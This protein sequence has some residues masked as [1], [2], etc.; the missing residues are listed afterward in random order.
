MLVQTRSLG[1]IKDEHRLLLE[2]VSMGK[3]GNVNAAL[4]V[5]HSAPDAR[6]QRHHARPRSLRWAPAQERI[7]RAASGL[8]PSGVS[9]RVL[10][11]SAAAPAISS[12]S[13]ATTRSLGMPD[14]AW[15]S[16]PV[17]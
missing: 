4:E 15:K 3:L 8:G 5:A 10:A 2:H 13:A 14:D 1:R 7:I 9:L 11:A 16:A 17:R 6:R 12:S